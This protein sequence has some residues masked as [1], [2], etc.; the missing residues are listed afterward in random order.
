MQDMRLRAIARHVLRPAGVVALGTVFAL[1]PA[2]IL[3]AQSPASQPSPAFEVASVKR[4]TSGADGGSFG[5]RPGGTVVVTNN[6]LRNIIRNTYGVQNS[7]IV[8]GP[9]WVNTERF[10]ITA[11]ANANPAPSE[12]LL[13]MRRLLA[14]RFRLVVHNE[15][16][17]TSVY[18]LIL[19]R[20]DG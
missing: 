15:A 14:D 5:S 1:D 10:D 9:D 17:E 7:Q 16:R 20:S 8:G 2:L 12:M 11:R 19:A 18:A 6:T 13:M 4:N 3:R